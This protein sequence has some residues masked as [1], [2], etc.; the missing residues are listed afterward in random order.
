MQPKSLCSSNLFIGSYI[1]NAPKKAIIKEHADGTKIYSTC[2]EGGGVLVEEVAQKHD[3]K[4]ARK[5][6]RRQ[7]RFV[8]IMS[9]LRDV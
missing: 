5:E 2:G 6:T 9:Q 7:Q 4:V 1:S 8:R 3:E